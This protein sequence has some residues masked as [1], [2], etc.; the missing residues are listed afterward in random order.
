VNTS[1]DSALLS[2][3]RTS[4]ERELKDHILPYWATAA[5]D[6]HNG[7]FV[8]RIDGL[9]VLDPSASKGAVLNAR[10]LWTFSAAARFLDEPRY[11]LLADRAFA[12]V[13]NHFWD[14][15]N[16][17]VY[18][19]LSSHGDVVNAK[20]Q[21]YAQAFAI[22]GFAE[23]HRATRSRE[24]LDRA[25]ELF[26]ILETRA[27]D[28]P[29]PGYL[30]AFNREWVLLP[31]EPLSERDMPAA[32]SANTHLHLLEAYSALFR[33]WPSAQLRERQTELIGLFL[34]QIID[35]DSHHMGEAFDERWIPLAEITSF[36]HDIEAAWLLTEA[37]ELVGDP[38]VDRA[39][40]DMAVTLAEVTLLEGVDGDAGLM[41]QAVDGI[42]SDTDK[43]WWVQAEAVV[44]FLNAFDIT[45]DS[46][47]LRAASSI[48]GYAQSR[49][50][51]RTHGEW[52]LRVSRDGEPYVTDDKVGPWK[53]PYH[54]ARACM[55][56]MSR[57]D[58]LTPE[59]E[60][61]RYGL[62]A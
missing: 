39:A 18:W 25:V 16:G 47:F 46:R 8:G 37:A 14:N 3:L 57:V 62:S 51:D 35:P 23:Y 2:A 11:R 58:R 48:W 10:I 54:A 45:G 5:V 21:T 29:R 61:G 7:G 4:A 40:R 27:S 60:T 31:S 42:L 6:E 20:K 24:A 22:Y 52:H 44:G 17:G 56:V 50:V 36:G 1:D 30:D 55:E 12:Y 53:C 41:N 26:E 59:A 32:K 33:V 38:A 43:H 34:D 28:R 15:S 49:L 9:G 19:M 13:T